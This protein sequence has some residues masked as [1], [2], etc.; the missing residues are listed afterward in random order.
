MKNSR[1]PQKL[2]LS[3]TKGSGKNEKLFKRQGQLTYKLYQ[4]LQNFYGII[5]HVIFKYS[6]HPGQCERH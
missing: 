3:H 2:M 1:L 4:M 5:P 6:L